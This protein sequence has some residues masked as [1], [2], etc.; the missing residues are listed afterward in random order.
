MCTWIVCTIV[1]RCIY[2]YIFLYLYYSYYTMQIKKINSY[3]IT[4]KNVT[5]LSLMNHGK[6]ISNFI[7]LLYI[8]VYILISNFIN[9]IIIVVIAML[10]KFQNIFYN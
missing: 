7:Y 4:S 8:F 5:S 10:L 1:C 6:L 9:I 3:T 2:F